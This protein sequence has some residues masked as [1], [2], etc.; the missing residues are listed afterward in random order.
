MLGRIQKSG[1]ENEIF[2]RPVL[3]S[4]HSDTLTP[5]PHALR[6]P[7]ASKCRGPCRGLKPL[8]PLAAKQNKGV[9]EMS[10]ESSWLDKGVSRIMNRSKPNDRSKGQLILK[11]MLPKKMSEVLLDFAEPLLEGLSPNADTESRKSVLQ[12]AVVIWNYSIAL[13]T[14]NQKYIKLFKNIRPM[15][16]GGIGEQVLALMMGRKESLYPENNTYIADFDLN[17]DEKESEYHLT[18]MSTESPK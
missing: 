18:V 5:L 6:G 13:K 8:P 1:Q 2:F 12:V 14:Q 9:I 7:S 17:W 4:A 15:F 16:D 11:N 10:P 3:T